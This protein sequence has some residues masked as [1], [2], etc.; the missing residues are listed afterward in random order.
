MR[1][2]ADLLDGNP[3]GLVHASGFQPDRRIRRPFQ[4]DPACPRSNPIGIGAPVSVPQIWGISH[5]A[6]FEWEGITNSVLLRN[7]AQAAAFEPRSAPL[8]A[9]PR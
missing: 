2:L 3:P 6:V 5:K 8:T 7:G 9:R 1:F 4:H